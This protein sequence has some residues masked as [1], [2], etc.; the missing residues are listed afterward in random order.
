MADSQL[1]KLIPLESSDLI[2]FDPSVL[3]M[4]KGYKDE[5]GKDL[6]FSVIETYLNT[7]PE[8]IQGI[9]TSM[10]INPKE[11]HRRT[12]TLKS[13]SATVG[14]VL[15]AKI[16]QSLELDWHSSENQKYLINAV[17][18]EFQKLKIEL[19]S[20]RSQNQK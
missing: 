5:Q 7:T 1:K 16:C 8:E 12:H 18:E 3:D 15:L 13:S 17:K 19:E 2:T 14:G 20:Y 6:R 4:L 11:F 10:E 9:E